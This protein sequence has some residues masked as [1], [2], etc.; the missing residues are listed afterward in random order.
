MIRL[1]VD[2]RLKKGFNVSQQE[3]RIR[4]IEINGTLPHAP[5]SWLE[6]QGHFHDLVVATYG[7]GFYI[8]DDISYLRTMAD[9]LARRPVALLPMRAA[10]R[11]RKVSTPTGSP[12]SLVGGQ[13]P[14]LAATIN[15]AVGTLPTDST[16]KDSVSFIV[17][18]ASGTQIRKF[19]GAPPK[20]GLNRALWDLRHDGPRKAKL[21]TAPPGNTF[22][23]VADSRPLVAWDL[24]LVGGQVGP[25]VAPG[26][27][28]VAMRWGRDTLRQRVDVRR[29]PNSEGTDADITAQVALA[30][31]IR[32]AMNET[33]ALIDE[34]EWSRRGFEQLRSNLRE[35]L[36]DLRE[37]GP[38][39]GRDLSIADAEAF[40]KEIDGVEKKVIEIESKLYDI[41]LTGAR[42]DAFRSPNQLYEKLASVG[43]DVSAS[44]SDF[45]PTDQH[46]QVYGM[47]REQLDGLKKQFSGLVANDLSAFAARAAKLG[48]TLP[49][50]F[51]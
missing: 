16:A 24:D 4:R 26:T 7:R 27:Y 20:R 45:R 21:R 32:E 33:V 19:K 41:T 15:Y 8:A 18:D 12:N 35:R 42:E 5:V 25:L 44:S 22:L 1:L 48:V 9:S 36:K 31:R 3:Q 13:D 37:Y 34:S 28:T 43:S 30:L 23:R 29:D 47:L 40:L 50:I 17:Y 39:P 2:G 11:F 38:S 10:Y 51:E 6:I 46:G 49:V 14:P